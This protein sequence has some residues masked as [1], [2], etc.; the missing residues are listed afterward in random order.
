M[1]NLN[2][3]SAVVQPCVNSHWLSQWKALVTLHFW[4]PTE[5]TYLNQS[6]K[7]LSQMI[8]STTS[9]DVQNLVEIRPWGASGQMSEILVI[10]SFFIYTL[11]KQLTYRSDR[12]PHLHA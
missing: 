3:G 5:L 4:P 11:F 1:Q 7:N 9:T 2:T 6:L 12:S 8:M 10:L